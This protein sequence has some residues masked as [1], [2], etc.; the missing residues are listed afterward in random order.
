[1]NARIQSVTVMFIIYMIFRLFAPAN[2]VEA[3]HPANKSDE[4]SY[5]MEIPNEQ[6]LQ[7]EQEGGVDF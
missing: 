1:M 4:R 5:L 2:F 6:Q 7:E 3:T